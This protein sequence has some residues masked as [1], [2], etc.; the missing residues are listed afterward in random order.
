MLFMTEKYD[1]DSSADDS[2][3]YSLDETTES[4]MFNL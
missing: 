2:K 3:P 1:I 4:A